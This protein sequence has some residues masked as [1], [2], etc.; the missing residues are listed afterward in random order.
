MANNITIKGLDELLK[1][2]SQ[3]S[4]LKPELRKVTDKATKYVWGEI[5]SYPSKPPASDYRRTG[6]LG[7]TMYSEVK[8][9]GNDIAGVVGNNTTYAPWVISAERIGSRGPQAGF[10]RHWYTLQ[11]VVEKAKSGVIQIYENWIKGLI[12]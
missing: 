7:R 9:I 8:E 5:P 11:S 3:L 6:T 1:K 4:D 10:N 12:N 2:Y